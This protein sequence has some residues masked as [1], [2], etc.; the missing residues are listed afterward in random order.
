MTSISLTSGEI[1]DIMHVLYV[2]E[3]QAQK[4][5]QDTHVSAYYWNLANKFDKIHRKLLDLP[6]E[7]RETTLVM[8]L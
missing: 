5:G 8:T 4:N 6:G 3:E 1:L 2:R 7:E